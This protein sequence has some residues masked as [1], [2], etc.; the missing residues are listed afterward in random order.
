[1][2]IVSC[3]AGIVCNTLFASC[4]YLIEFLKNQSRV[5]EILLRGLAEIV[6]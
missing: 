3:I 6:E 1:M 5:S 2:S 4:K